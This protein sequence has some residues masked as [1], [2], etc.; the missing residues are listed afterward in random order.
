ML[1]P[2]TDIAAYIYVIFLILAVMVFSNSVGLRTYFE[3]SESM[4]RLF[5]SS[6]SSDTHVDIQ[7]RYA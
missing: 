3:D 1:T 6:F 2:W 5:A 4:S 7:V